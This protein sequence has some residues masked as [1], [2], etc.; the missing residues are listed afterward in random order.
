MCGIHRQETARPWRRGCLYVTRGQ[1]WSPWVCCV[2]VE[3]DLKDICLVCGHQEVEGDLL[4]WGWPLLPVQLKN[5]SLN[6]AEQGTE[7]APIAP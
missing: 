6:Q 4:Q 1:I 2:C 5:L 3:S 7:P